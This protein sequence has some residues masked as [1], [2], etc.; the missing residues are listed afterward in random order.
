MSDSKTYDPSVHCAYATRF[1]KIDDLLDDC[2]WNK[3]DHK[4]M[5][6]G[7]TKLS[8]E[9]WQHLLKDRTKE[10]RARIRKLFNQ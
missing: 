10:R 6:S 5:L 9:Q 1:I 2:Q 7:F 8:P 3:E 4:T